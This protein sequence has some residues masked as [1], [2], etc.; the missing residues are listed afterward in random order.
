MLRL[1]AAHEVATVVA[2]PG[3]EQAAVARLQAA[4]EALAAVDKVGAGSCTLLPGSHK[5]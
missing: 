4:Q 2:G 5:R 1:L 3:A